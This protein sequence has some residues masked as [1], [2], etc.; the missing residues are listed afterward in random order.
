M[1]SLFR[2]MIKWRPIK[3]ESGVTAVEYGL[4]VASVAIAIATALSL[5]GT[6]LSRVFN[7]VATSL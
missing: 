6:N 4:I 2:A 1:L 3:S 5:V 7:H